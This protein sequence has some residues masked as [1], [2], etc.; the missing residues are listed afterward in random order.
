MRKVFSTLA[1][2]TLLLLGATTTF[3]QRWTQI[4]D[5]GDW[6]KTT[7]ITTT[8]GAFWSIEK[9]GTLF[10]TD[11]NGKYTQM[12]DKGEFYDAKF[13]VGLGNS[14]YTIEG[15]DL[16][17]TSTSS[18]KWQKISSDYG[19]TIAITAMDNKLYSIEKDG[20]LYETE[21]DGTWRQIG[22]TG[23]FHGA[24]LLAAYDG[25]L[26]TIEQGTLYKTNPSTSKWKQVGKTG[27]WVDADDMV[28]SGGSLW[29]T[30]DDGTLY[31]VDTKGNWTEIKG[32]YSDVSWLL[33][34][35]DELYVVASGTLYRMNAK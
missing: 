6:V 20:S 23:D 27:D 18:L 33:A 8:A 32:D 17:R 30:E 4:G 1:V 35:D 24:K 5:K 12:G 26:W 29:I 15:G 34:L 11:K 3:A 16:Y 19:K 31:K 14:L 21:P 2:C 28:A 13:I 9:D 7:D 10:R 22:E 25:W